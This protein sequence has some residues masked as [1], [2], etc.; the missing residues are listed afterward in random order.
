MS[1]QK[2]AFCQHIV[3]EGEAKEK[4]EEEDMEEQTQQQEEEGGI[5]LK[6]YTEL[7]EEEGVE[8][9]PKEDGTVFWGKLHLPSTSQPQPQMEKRGGRWGVVHQEDKVPQDE[10]G[11]AQLQMKVHTQEKTY[12][13]N[14]F[15][16]VP[17]KDLAQKDNQQDISGNVESN[18]AAINPSTPIGGELHILTG[19]Q[20]S[21]KTCSSSSATLEGPV[22]SYENFS[23]ASD[24]AVKVSTKDDNSTLLTPSSFG[25]NVRDSSRICNVS[26]P[27]ESVSFFQCE[28]GTSNEAANT[29]STPQ[30]FVIEASLEE[31]TDMQYISQHDINVVSHYRVSPP[32]SDPSQHYISSQNTNNSSSHYSSTSEEHLTLKSCS[33]H[34][35][36]SRPIPVHQPA[37]YDVSGISLQITTETIEMADTQESVRITKETPTVVKGKQNK[38]SFKDTCNKLKIENPITRGRRSRR[39]EIYLENMEMLTYPV[40]VTNKCSG[41]HKQQQ[42]K[43]ERKNTTLKLIPLIRKLTADEILA[44]TQKQDLNTGSNESK[45]ANAGVLIPRKVSEPRVCK[46]P[47]EGIA[48]DKKTIGQYHNALEAAAVS[49]LESEEIEYATRQGATCEHENAFHHIDP[50]CQPST[51]SG[52]AT[53]KDKQNYVCPSAVKDHFCRNLNYKTDR[54][55]SA[56]QCR[57]VRNVWAK[58]YRN[59]YRVGSTALHENNEQGG[60]FGGEEVIAKSFSA[61]TT[62][63]RIPKAENRIS[64]NQEQSKSIRQESIV[65]EKL[66][67]TRSRCKQGKQKQQNKQETKRKKLMRDCYRILARSPLESQRHIA[68]LLSQEFTIKIT[69]SHAKSGSCATHIKYPKLEPHELQTVQEQTQDLDSRQDVALSAA[70]TPQCSA[71]FDENTS[72]SDEY[73]LNEIEITLT[74]N[75]SLSKTPNAGDLGSP[76]PPAVTL[77]TM[78]KSV[79]NSPHTGNLDMTNGAWQ[80][81]NDTKTTGNNE[82]PVVVH[83]EYLNETDGTCFTPQIEYIDLTCDTVTH[84]VD[85]TG[86]DISAEVSDSSQVLLTLEQAEQGWKRTSQSVCSPYELRSK[87]ARRDS[88]VQ[89]K[90]SYQGEASGC[91]EDVSMVNDMDISTE[92][93][94]FA[95]QYEEELESVHRQ[96]EKIESKVSNLDHWEIKEVDSQTT[97]FLNHNSTNQVNPSGKQDGDDIR[98]SESQMDSSCIASYLAIKSRSSSQTSLL[99]SNFATRSRDPFLPIPIFLEDPVQCLDLAQTTGYCMNSVPALCV[100]E[101]VVNLKVNS[102]QSTDV[103]R[104]N[105]MDGLR[106]IRNNSCSSGV[107]SASLSDIDTLME[108]DEPEIPLY[109]SKIIYNHSDSETSSASEGETCGEN[110]A[111]KPNCGQHALTTINTEMKSSQVLEMHNYSMTEDRSDKGINSTSTSTFV[112]RNCGVKLSSQHTVLKGAPDTCGLQDGESLCIQQAVVEFQSPILSRIPEVETQQSSSRCQS[113]ILSRKPEVETQ[114]SSSRCQ[115]PILSRKSEEKSCDV[116]KESNI[117]E[118]TVYSMPFPLT[119]TTTV[120]NQYESV[121]SPIGR[122]IEN[123]L[124]FEHLGTSSSQKQSPEYNLNVLQLTSDNSVPMEQKQ[125]DQ[126][127]QTENFKPFLDESQSKLAKENLE[128]EERAQLDADIFDSKQV[129]GIYEQNTEEGDENEQKK[130]KLCKDG[131]EKGELYIHEEEREEFH[132][133]EEVKE[134][135]CEFEQER[136]ELLKRRNEEQDTLCGDEQKGN[137]FC[138]DEDQSVT[139]ETDE[140]QDM[141]C[142]GKQVG[143]Q[144]CLDKDQGVSYEADEEWGKLHIDEKQPWLQSKKDQER[145]MQEREMPDHNEDQKQLGQDETCENELLKNELV[146]DDI[147]KSELKMGKKC[148]DEDGTQ[149]GCR[150]TEN[151]RRIV[152][153]G[154]N[155]SSTGIVQMEIQGNDSEKEIEEVGTEECEPMGERET[156]RHDAREKE[157]KFSGNVCVDHVYPVSPKI[158]LTQPSLTYSTISQ[159]GEISSSGW[160]TLCL[161]DNVTGDGKRHTEKDRNDIQETWD[162]SESMPL[163]VTYINKAQ[164]MNEIDTNRKIIKD[165]NGTFVDNVNKEAE[166]IYDEKRTDGNCITEEEKSLYEHTG[167]HELDELLSIAS[168]P[169]DPDSPIPEASEDETKSSP[170]SPDSSSRSDDE[171]VLSIYASSFASLDSEPEEEELSGTVS[172]GLCKQTEVVE[173]RRIT[174]P[175]CMEPIQKYN[176]L[177]G[178]NDTPSTSLTENRQNE[179]KDGSRQ[180]KILTCDFDLKFNLDTSSDDDTRV[181]TSSIVRQI[182]EREAISD[183]LDA[184]ELN[185]EANLECSSIKSP[186]EDNDCKHSV[187]PQESDNCLNTKQ[188]STTKM[189]PEVAVHTGMDVCNSS[190]KKETKTKA[191]CLG[192]SISSVPQQCFFKLLAIDSKFSPTPSSVGEFSPSHIES[193]P[194]QLTLDHVSHILS[195]KPKMK[196][197]V[198]KEVSSASHEQKASNPIQHQEQNCYREYHANR[199]SFSTSLGLQPPPTGSHSI[200]SVYRLPTNPPQPSYPRPPLMQMPQQPY[201]QPSFGSGHLQ[202]PFFSSSIPSRSWGARE[203]NMHY[204]RSKCVPRPHLALNVG[205]C[206]SFLS[207]GICRRPICRWMHQLNIETEKYV[208]TLVL[209]YITTGQCAAAWRLVDAHVTSASRPRSSLQLTNYQHKALQLSPTHPAL[210]APLLLLPLARHIIERDGSE[211]VSNIMVPAHL[212]PALNAAKVHYLCSIQQGRKAYNL[213]SFSLFTVPQSAVHPLVAPFIRY[214][215]QFPDITP[216]PWE[217]VIGWGWEKESD[218]SSKVAESLNLTWLWVSMREHNLHRVYEVYTHICKSLTHTSIFFTHITCMVIDRFIQRGERKMS[219][220]VLKEVQRLKANDVNIF[221]K[222]IPTKK[223]EAMSLIPEMRQVGWIVVGIRPALPRITWDLLFTL[224]L[225]SLSDTALTLLLLLCAIQVGFYVPEVQK[226]E[227]VLNDCMKGS[228]KL[229]RP[230]SMLVCALPSTLLLQ[231]RSTLSR[232]VDYLAHAPPPAQQVR[233]NIT[234]HCKTYGINLRPHAEVSAYVVHNRTGTYPSV[235][236]SKPHPQHPC[237]KTGADFVTPLQHNDFVDSQNVT[238]ISTSLGRKEDIPKS[239]HYSG[240]HSD[241]YALREGKPRMPQFRVV[242]RACADGEMAPLPQSLFQIITDL[243]DKNSSHDHVVQEVD[244]EQ[245]MDNSG[246]TEFQKS[247]SQNT[248]EMKTFSPIHPSVTENINKIDSSGPFFQEKVRNLTTDIKD[249]ICSKPQLVNQWCHDHTS[250]LSGSQKM[251]PMEKHSDHVQCVSGVNPVQLPVPKSSSN[252]EVP[253]ECNNLIFSSTSCVNLGLRDQHFSADACQKSLNQIVVDGGADIRLTV[254]TGIS[255]DVTEKNASTSN[256]NGSYFI[257]NSEAPKDMSVNKLS[258]SKPPLSLLQANRELSI[259]ERKENLSVLSR[260]SE[261]SSSCSE[262]EHNSMNEDESF[263]MPL[264]LLSWKGTRSNSKTVWTV[265]KD[266]SALVIPLDLPSC[267]GSSIGKPTTTQADNVSKKKSFLANMKRSLPCNKTSKTD[268]V[269][270]K[271][272]EW[273]VASDFDKEL[274]TPECP[275]FSTSK[276]KNL[277]AIKVIRKSLKRSPQQKKMPMKVDF[278]S[279]DKA[280]KKGTAK[281]TQP[282]SSRIKPS[283]TSDKVDP[284]IKK[285]SETEQGLDRLLPIPIL[286]ENPSSATTMQDLMDSPVPM[287]PFQ[288]T[289]EPPG[290]KTT[291]PVMVESPPS[292]RILDAMV[293]DTE[294]CSGPTLIDPDIKNRPNVVMSKQQQQQAVVKDRPDA[295][296][297]KQQQQLAEDCAR[298]MKA[299]AVCKPRQ[300]TVRVKE[301]VVTMTKG[302]K[303]QSAATNLHALVKEVLDNPKEKG[304]GDLTETVSEVGARM[305]LECV[306]R[307]ELDQAEKIIIVL[308]KHAIP[309]YTSEIEEEME[310]EC[311]GAELSVAALSVLHCTTNT[312]LFATILEE[313]YWSGGFEAV[314]QRLQLLA[315]VLG[316]LPD[317]QHL[318]PPAAITMRETSQGELHNYHYLLS[319]KAPLLNQE[320]LWYQEKILGSLVSYYQHDTNTLGQQYHK[321]IDLPGELQQAWTRM[322]A[323]TT[324]R[325]EVTKLSRVVVE[326]VMADVKVSDR[327]TE[328]ANE[329]LAKEMNASGNGSTNAELQLQ[330]VFE[331]KMNR[332]RLRGRKQL[333]TNMKIHFSK[334]ERWIVD[335]DCKS[336]KLGMVSKSLELSGGGCACNINEGRQSQQ[337]SAVGKNNVAVQSQQC[338]STGSPS[339]SLCK[340]QKIALGWRTSVLMEGAARSN[341]TDLAKG[342]DNGRINQIKKGFK[343]GIKRNKKWKGH[344]RPL[345]LQQYVV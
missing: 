180:G 328:K 319:H 150:K 160:M 18:S 245:L 12:M 186:H 183:L 62:P 340:D 161:H 121:Q 118:Q 270:G 247:R 129:K 109:N 310:G 282:A 59:R 27:V 83:E 219:F 277:E 230:L 188:N 131:R 190:F 138:L 144:L 193:P 97:V 264:E 92:N 342:R 114:Q 253:G 123:Q 54:M 312:Y 35:S 260:K 212:T 202:I 262:A 101:E 65:K 289:V 100:H 105:L 267:K 248:K 134:K 213:L 198:G 140:E 132:Q 115:S 296:M 222:L 304:D 269:S 179:L 163:E 331:D 126:N 87:R 53:V 165:E 141:V 336:D 157:G 67:V 275:I 272:P 280:T 63:C 170:D 148:S 218:S 48:S 94:D 238:D 337:S 295:I 297:L 191:S 1:L 89:E 214:C 44:R 159:V 91:T 339:K 36:T 338:D 309:F 231:L 229:L 41:P 122:C 76:L 136:E 185:L 68:E 308:H 239:F 30:R 156:E 327:L 82:L 69:P 107:P 73:K 345:M 77:S 316:T 323:W 171:D 305:M 55:T 261:F 124:S 206:F 184:D 102:E 16:I 341:D 228:S 19:S 325:E 72:P 226:V 155:K 330:G 95:V 175:V 112:S 234:R 286:E 90:E 116:S 211:T 74:V 71:I 210:L 223:D 4:G 96:V 51:R 294:G 258:L 130:N 209:H 98:N 40:K 177:K 147:C 298:R 303:I 47:E 31:N 24:T 45:S 23:T 33:A 84:N 224:A 240:N 313:V 14:H 111:V 146:K 17:L 137:Q 49:P 46:K 343:R 203:Q 120:V 22:S 329:Y 127:E 176:R 66:E 70:A 324:D 80:T 314:Q 257:S 299:I 8:A 320:V 135:P 291:P 274:Q 244:N 64:Q 143:N 259:F 93:D 187:A 268:E 318:Q 290:S 128:G 110:F 201:R 28:S 103:N 9:R 217:K 207:E 311:S 42:K 13:Q 322:E 152:A 43:V 306:D 332:K 108:G 293:I 208:G 21:E 216:S 281:F 232:L 60:N 2:M 237:S 335:Y 235:Q 315:D 181:S 39:P 196:P 151:T 215:D 302:N 164:S 75:G 204:P 276:E 3:R 251:Q 86:A 263:V 220:W 139:Y 284:H 192:T 149:Q 10:L 242:R 158:I 241:N 266:D 225:T 205:S 38:H 249:S 283:L 5:G 56:D 250:K 307:G 285:V 11:L 227:R 197:L 252:L 15:E 153:A 243:I 34:T 194:R 167:I 189:D 254:R 61:I 57:K 233:Y 168:T 278:F 166:E 178:R 78:S 256:L 173:R 20:S 326:A 26:V 125:D 7:E 301:L 200:P 119:G 169:A 273:S 321:L 317:P 104:D 58:G 99:S 145:E 79:H 221:L 113:P 344:N 246:L 279:S 174:L 287:T 154:E 52:G 133:V 29:D 182:E 334:E 50:K 81:A 300:R 37:P 255:K 88:D 265:E 142:V 333:K 6:E 195:E 32:A 288:G 106:E 172:H 199:E 25:N 271:H 162:T 292:C 85:S 236:Q 117:A